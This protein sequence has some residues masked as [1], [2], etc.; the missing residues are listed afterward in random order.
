MILFDRMTQLDLGAPYEVF[1]RMPDTTVELVA[2]SRDAVVADG[3]FAIVPQATFADARPADLLFVPGGFGVNDAMLDTEL[4][5]FVRKQAERAQWITSVCSGSLIL[6]AAGLLRGYEATTHWASVDMLARF[7]ARPVG[8]RVVRDR[9]RITAGGV[10]SGTDFALT[11]AAELYGEPLAKTIQLAIEYDPQPP[12][13]SGSPRVADD[14][15]LA[16]VRQ[17]LEKSLAA[18][19]EAI[20]IAVARMPE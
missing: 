7:G 6:G 4:I 19:R 16:T 11:V 3:G 14:A 10:T 2:K 9:N 17:R 13:N 5:A 8:K 18:R 12:F 20:E 1:I 15:T